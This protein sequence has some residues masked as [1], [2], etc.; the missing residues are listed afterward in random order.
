M[1]EDM[2]I[3]TY[4]KPETTNYFVEHELT[5]KI[6]REYNCDYVKDIERGSRMIIKDYNKNNR[7]TFIIIAN[8]I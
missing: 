4:W 6:A 7:G 8:V 2:K 5:L 3:K 1:N